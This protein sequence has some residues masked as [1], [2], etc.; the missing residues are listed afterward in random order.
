MLE[1]A[2]LSIRQQV[3]RRETGTEGTAARTRLMTRRNESE[4]GVF[5]AGRHFLNDSSTVKSIRLF[6]AP[7]WLRSVTPERRLSF[8]E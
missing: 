5:V 7:T 3:H 2:L 4:T 6:L 8:P 1:P